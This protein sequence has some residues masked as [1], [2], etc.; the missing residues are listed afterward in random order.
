MIDDEQRR[1]SPDALLEQAKAASRGK[2]KIYLGAAPG[3]GKTYEML[4]DARKKRVENSDVIVGVVETHGRTET[5][6]LLDG[7]EILPRKSGEMDLDAI[8]TRRPAI[9]LVDELAH[10]NANGARHPKRWNDVEEILAAGIDVWSTLNVQHIES[11]NDVV[12]R[13]TRVRVRETVPDAVV[14]RADEIQLIDLTPD[15]LIE[16]LQQGKVY[17]PEQA[18]RA[19]SNY[20][21][22]GNLSALRE[23]AMRRAADTIDEQV[24]GHRRAQG[25]QAPWA[26]GERI[27]VCVD[28]REASAEIVR[29]AKR[30]ADRS[31]APWLAV[32]VE[33]ARSA[34]LSETERTRLAETLRLAERLGAETATL[35]GDNVAETLLAY[36]RDQNV[37][38]IILGKARR[39]P[40]FEAVFG[41]VVRRLIDSS[42]SIP[43]EVVPEPVNGSQ[44]A[45]FP[46]SRIWPALTYRA[47]AEALAMTAVATLVCWPLDVWLQVSNLTLVYLAVVLVSALTRGLW[48]GLITGLASAIAFNWFYTLPR[49]TLT[50]A[51]PDNVLAIL[52]FSG[53]ALIVSLLAARARQQTLAARNEARTS[54]ELFGLSR[55]LTSATTEDEAADAIAR[56]AARA[57]DAD[58]VVLARVGQNDLRVAGAS[59]DVYDLSDADL[60]AARWTA[61]KGEATGRGADTLPGARWLFLPLR[62]S[63]L[64]AG[65]V[66]IARTGTL[67]P[68]ERRRLAAMGDQAATAMERAH[69]AI[70]LEQSR[71]E[72]EAERLRGTMLASL[73]H[74]LRT[75]IAGILGAASSLR[76]YGDRHDAGTRDELLESIE[77]ESAR[78]QRYIEKL[79][80]MTRLDAGSIEAKLEMLDP[81]DILSAAAKRAEG[82]GDGRTLK[83]DIEPRLPMI[84][85][86]AV[87]ADQA[88]FNLIENAITHA[89]KGDITLIAR[90]VSKGVALEVQDEGSGIAPGEE[91][92][93]FDRFARGGSTSVAGVGLGLA[94]VKGFAGLM[95]ARVYARNRPDR[96]GAVFSIVFDGDA[97]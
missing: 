75:P 71:V 92:R 33:T 52:A 89:R 79:L 45:F 73:S 66:G 64:I 27:L 40:V 94:I 82:L 78:M 61:E 55:Q 95:N 37:T 83:L 25:E 39:S 24:R 32:H 67:T 46:I 41:S 88:L 90:R 3:V 87:L 70:A 60:A 42:G 31:K 29:H 44:K 7:L 56:Y 77:T 4:S 51:D 85:A 65:V 17:A 53:A 74:D 80:D 6:A 21:V 57:F 36:A 97:V 49:Y 93:I 16:R 11:L 54:R 5:A 18:Q 96:S 59:Q 10:T 1:P 26:A 68:A 23:L 19:L 20:F 84:E 9:V 47:V 72:T 28:E 13:I 15:E 30:L 69:V 50:V 43:I 34:R 76:A 91:A 12:A 14:E 63:R 22:P 86:D 38:Q 81:A 62:T 35:P 58:C 48:A 8:L 2:L